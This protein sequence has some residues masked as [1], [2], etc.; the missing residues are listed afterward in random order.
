MWQRHL[1]FVYHMDFLYIHLGNKTGSIFV[2][3]V[4]TNL[5]PGCFFFSKLSFENEMKIFFRK[6]NFFC[7]FN[8]TCD[9]VFYLELETE[10]F[11]FENSFFANKLETS[12]SLCNAR[13]IS[14]IKFSYLKISSLKT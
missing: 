5:F 1:I 6:K 11:R 13:L 3:K 4:K 8:L 12:R 10:K 14:R 7:C 2:I 9:S